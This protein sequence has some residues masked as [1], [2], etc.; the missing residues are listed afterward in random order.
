MKRKIQSK[1]IIKFKQKEKK[2]IW[3]WDFNVHV[4]KRDQ[5]KKRTSAEENSSGE[6]E[7]LCEEETP[8][9]RKIAYKF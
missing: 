8:S 1:G 7:N 6:D 2:L 4:K 3:K 9:P 5:V